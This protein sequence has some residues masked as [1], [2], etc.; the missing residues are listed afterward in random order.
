MDII[1]KIKYKLWYMALS[2]YIKEKKFAAGA[3]IGVKA[4]RSYFFYLKRNKKLQMIG[5]DLWEDQPD[6]PY[7][8]NLRNGEKALKRNKQFEN[9][10]TLYKGDAVEVGSKIKDGSLD[11]IFYDLFNYRISTVKL[12]REI[13]KPWLA[14]LKSTGVLIGRDFHEP[15]IAQAI[16]ELTSKSI[17]PIIVNGQPHIRLKEVRLK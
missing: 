12:H 14:K 16:K 15:D 9:R 13:I 10:S 4:G 1:Q 3:E 8:N 7:K 11:F 5:L 17:A 6:S 2:K